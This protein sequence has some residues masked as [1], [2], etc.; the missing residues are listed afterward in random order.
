VLLPLIVGVW[1]VRN[2]APVRS[3][4]LATAAV[5]AIGA[6]SLNVLV[7]YTGQISLGHQAFIG[8]GAFTSAYIIS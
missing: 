4:A 7:G 8:I 1:Y 3:D 5:I 6:L 2:N